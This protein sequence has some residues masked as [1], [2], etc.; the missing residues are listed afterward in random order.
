ML[1]RIFVFQSLLVLGLKVSVAQAE[2]PTFSLYA[3]Y[4]TQVHCRGRLFVSSVGD[5]HLLQL[6]AFPKE[7]GCGVVLKPKGPL[8]A[9]DLLLKTSTGD[10]HFIVDIQ[11][12]PLGLKSTQLEIHFEPNGLKGE[13]E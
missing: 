8:G 9:T 1:K 5:P 2:I 13:S 12:A 7:L 3:G 11:K 10:Y 6:E 4:L